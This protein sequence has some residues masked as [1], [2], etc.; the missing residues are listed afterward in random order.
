MNLTRPTEVKALLN[1]LGIH[2]NRVL[3]QNFLI[4]ANILRIMLATARV[5]RDDA[6]LEVGPG[7]GV[8]TE[9]LFARSRPG[10]RRRERPRPLRTSERNLRGQSQA[11]VDSRGYPGHR[12]G[13]TD[14][15]RHQQGRRQPALLHQQPSPC[16]TGQMRQAST[17]HHRHRT[18]RSGGTHH[19]PNRHRRLRDSRQFLLQVRYETEISKNISPSCFYPPPDISSSI[20][21]LTLRDQP[22]AVA[23]S[24][25]HFEDL[26][27]TCFSQRRKQI[28]KLLRAFGPDSAE[29]ALAAIGIDPHSRPEELPPEQWVEL[30]NALPRIK[31][32]TENH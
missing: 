16:G 10:L 21:S 19:R 1:R 18:A 3:G 2:P 25:P 29:K 5:T 9:G 14:V 27:K 20:V 11:H 8:L 13:R 17:N 31:K 22:L 32:T 23:S 28:G 12:P 6:V 24:R 26:V 15:L 4:D 30:S 7:L